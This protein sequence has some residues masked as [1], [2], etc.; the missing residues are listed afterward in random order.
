[1]AFPHGLRALNHAA[2]RSFF[3][4]QLAALVGSWMQTVSLVLARPPAD[5]LAVQARA[6]RHAPVR[7]DPAPLPVR[8]GDRRSLVAAR[9]ADRLPGGPR[10]PGVG[11]RAPGRHRPRPLLAD[12]HALAR[13]RARPRAR[14]PGPAVVRDAARRTGG[15]RERR[16]AQLG[17]VQHGAHRGSGRRRHP[18]RAVRRRAGVRGQWSRVRRGAGHAAP[19]ARR[20]RAAHRR[21][22][23]AAR[24]RGG[25][26][27]CV[28][29]P[30]RA[31][32][33]GPPLRREPLCLQLRRLRA[34]SRA[35]GPRPGA[36]GVRLPD[37]RSR[38]GRRGGGA[39]PG[40]PRQPRAP[41]RPAARGGGRG[42]R[43]AS[44]AL[45]GP[46]CLDRRRP[47]RRDG[48][49][50]DRRRD[51]VQHVPPAQHA[52]TRSAAGS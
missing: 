20:S 48:L 19:P 16:R 13:H 3:L 26:S 24:L 28:P 34:A 29:D 18:D 2:F 30:P 9:S 35:H 11:A 32:P 23:H 12:R 17:V 21:H 14:R 5:G 40:H 52:R 39:G 51:R 38:R 36:R 25:P 31:D 49:H 47:A 15:P 10:M 6:S 46:S 1:M 50:R 45:D 42:L 41:A 43:R 22:L 8:G 4:A 27:I 44:R 7:P 33:T 37:G